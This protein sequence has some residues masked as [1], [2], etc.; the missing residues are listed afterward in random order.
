[1]PEFSR[2]ANKKKTAILVR[3]TPEEADM[4]RRAAALERRTLSGFILN[5]VMN[6]LRARADIAGPRGV[7]PLRRKEDLT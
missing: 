1:M 2:T 6:R 4:I 3:C 7:Q 5:S